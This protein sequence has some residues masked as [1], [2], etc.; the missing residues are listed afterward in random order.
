[1]RKSLWLAPPLASLLFV[2]G[3]NTCNTGNCEATPACGPAAPACG[4]VSAAVA[5]EPVAVASADAGVVVD[6]GVKPE[7]ATDAP[8]VVAAKPQLVGVGVN[9]SGDDHESLQL[10]AADVPAPNPAGGEIL[11]EAEYARLLAEGKVTAIPGYT[12]SMEVAS[13]KT[14]T[15]KVVPA[16]PAVIEMAA[17]AKVEAAP[18]GAIVE[19]RPVVAQPVVDRA[20][21]DDA[22]LSTKEVAITADQ[23]VSPSMVIT[24]AQI[25]K[26]AMVAAVTA[27][28]AP[29]TAPKASLAAPVVATVPAAPVSTAKVVSSGSAVPTIP[30]MPLPE[31]WDYIHELDLTGG[32]LNTVAIDQLYSSIPS[33]SDKDI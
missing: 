15:R 23:L 6:V 5:V 32:T 18:A 27:P 28:K 30:G 4:A 7:A 8:I 2:V 1:M 3:C 29:V 14:E 16:S 31:G 25:N 10:A 22:G 12:P 21:K 33:G 26:S 11:S 24:P 13:A 19:R 17:K 20:V 9:T